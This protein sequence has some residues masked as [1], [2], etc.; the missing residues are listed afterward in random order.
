MDISESAFLRSLRNEA[1]R[2]ADFFARRDPNTSA[3][4]R[5]IESLTHQAL[6]NQ[7]TLRLILSSD[8]EDNPI[9]KPCE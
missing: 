9:I 6:I 7:D 3:S 4:W 5:C 1:G 8:Q 2:Q